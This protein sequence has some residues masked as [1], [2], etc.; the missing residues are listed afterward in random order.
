MKLLNTRTKII[1]SIASLGIVL[2]IVSSEGIAQ[3][4][5]ET[6]PNPT[7][8]ISQFHRIE[9][10]LSNKILVTFSGVGLIT[11]E[12]WWFL[13]SQPKSQKAITASEE[14]KKYSNRP[15]SS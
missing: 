6:H 15:P 1:S 12:L 4:T 9:Q 10:P 2:G 13:L 5:H 8:K 3:T 14:S 11:L 7:E